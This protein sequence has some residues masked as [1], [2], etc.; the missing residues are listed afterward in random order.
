MFEEAVGG[1]VARKSLEERP[2]GLWILLADL[3]KGFEQHQVRHQ[4]DQRVSREV[5]AGP[6][7]PELAFVAG[8]GR[9][10]PA[11]RVPHVPTRR[12]GG[13]TPARN[14]RPHHL[15]GGPCC[16]R[17]RQPSA[18]GRSVSHPTSPS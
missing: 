10:N 4:V 1:R 11:W 5:L 18:P 6:P 12:P 2:A 13:P 15:W 16:P 14:R 17:L 9:R 7:V 8:A 3:E